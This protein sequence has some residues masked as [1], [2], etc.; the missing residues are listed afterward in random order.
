MGSLPS[1]H[2]SFRQGIEDVANIL[3]MLEKSL[4]RPLR[5][6]LMRLGNPSRNVV[7]QKSEEGDVIM[8]NPRRVWRVPRILFCHSVSQDLAA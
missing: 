3:A 5:N 8:D 6:P 1:C 7:R 4:L 2:Q